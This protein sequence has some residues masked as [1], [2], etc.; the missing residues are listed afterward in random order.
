M[1]PKVSHMLSSAASVDL[2]RLSIFGADTTQFTSGGC[3]FSGLCDGLRLGVQAR[4]WVGVFG[5]G[6]GT[7]LPQLNVFND[8]QCGPVS[9]AMVLIMSCKHCGEGAGPPKAL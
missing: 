6:K 5:S 1:R 3:R 9:N 8:V 2:R 7:V 4:V